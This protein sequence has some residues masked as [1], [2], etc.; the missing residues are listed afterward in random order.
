DHLADLLDIEVAPH[1]LGLAAAEQSAGADALE[2]VSEHLRDELR[3]ELLGGPAHRLA[4]A[5]GGGR[6]DGVAPLLGDTLAAGEAQLGG[7]RQLRESGHSRAPVQRTS[8]SACRAPAALMACRIE[9]M[10]RG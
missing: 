7:G 10:S 9:I 4:I 2:H 5:A 8:S 3:L 6:L 1:A